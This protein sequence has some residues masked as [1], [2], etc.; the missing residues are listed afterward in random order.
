M[1]KTKKSWFERYLPGHIKKTRPNIVNYSIVNAHWKAISDGQTWTSGCEYSPLDGGC[2]SRDPVVAGSDIVVVRGAPLGIERKRQDSKNWYVLT[3]MDP[4]SG[5][6]VFHTW[7]LSGGL[8]EPRIPLLQKVICKWDRTGRK[9]IEKPQNV[10]DPHRRPRYSHIFAGTSPSIEE[11]ARSLNTF[12]SKYSKQIFNMEVLN[13]SVCST[14]PKSQITGPWV[15]KWIPVCPRL[16]KKRGTESMFC[17]H[18]TPSLWWKRSQVSFT[19]RSDRIVK[20]GWL[21][22]IDNCYATVMSLLQDVLKANLEDIDGSNLLNGRTNR[23]R[24]SLEE[25]LDSDDDLVNV[26]RVSLI[27]D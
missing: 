3:G 13:D 4:W 14:R 10:A 27:T 21:R 19:D 7:R 2:S 25:T 17:H 9:H 22:A 15:L 6:K 8:L 26:V 20:F 5:L 1:D 18:Q 11:V 24:H 16:Y 12:F 23:M